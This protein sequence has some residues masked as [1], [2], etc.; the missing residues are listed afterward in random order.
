V[1][2]KRTTVKFDVF[3]YTFTII[4]AENVQ[5]TAKRLG[6]DAS[7]AFAC[8]ITQPD[9]PKRSWLVFRTDPTPG[10]IAHESSHAVW[11]MLTTVGAEMDDETFAYHLHYL[12]ASI[13][14]FMKRF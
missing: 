1:P 3:E 14:E 13:H 7:G 8:F 4:R 2:N 12:V 6:A 5:R 10:A 11:H 9:K